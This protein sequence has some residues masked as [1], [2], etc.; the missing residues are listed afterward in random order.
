LTSDPDNDVAYNALG[1]IYKSQGL[2]PQ[3]IKA[4]RSSVRINGRHI[5]GSGDASSGLGRVYQELGRW[6][7]AEAMFR[8]AL[9]LK[10]HDDKARFEL[11]EFYR[12]RGRLPDAQRLYREA[13]AINPGNDW[14][15]AALSLLYA[16]LGDTVLART[17]ARQ[18]ADLRS[19][20][21]P[22]TTRNYRRLKELLDA[23][24]IRLVCVQYPME[25]VAPLRRIFAGNEDELLFVDN[26]AIFRKAVTRDSYARYFRDLFGG[27]FGHCTPEGNQLLAENIASS[28]LRRYFVK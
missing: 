28:I 24:G 9:E 5:A 21:N 4:F 23:K 27:D 6:P 11:A 1:V 22:M 14:A 13:L 8:K 7:E 10:P 17:Y 19:R 15:S 16:R 3:S 20:S 2:Y 25:S 26:E 12:E 18:T